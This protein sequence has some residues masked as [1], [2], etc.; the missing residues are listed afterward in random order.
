ME[1]WL[2]IDIGDYALIMHGMPTPPHYQRNRKNEWFLIIFCYF[3]FGSA[4]ILEVN[5]MFVLMQ[6]W[7]ATG[8]RLHICFYHEGFKHGSCLVQVVLFRFMI[9]HIFRI[10]MFSYINIAPFKDCIVTMNLLILR[11]SIYAEI[12]LEITGW[13]HF[14][15]LYIL[16][17][18]ILGLKFSESRN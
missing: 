1:N 3:C 18:M 11:Y 9:F 17:K 5:N 4:T 6:V 7:K 14:W 12:I 2:Y 10:K 15:F 13:L 16:S 8:R